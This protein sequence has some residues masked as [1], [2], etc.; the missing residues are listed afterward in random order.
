MDFVFA[1]ERL[2]VKLRHWLNS[3]LASQMLLM[4]WSTKIM[5]EAPIATAT[6]IV[7]KKAHSKRTFCVLNVTDIN[8]V[9]R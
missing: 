1:S 6:K 9:Y 2:V 5:V 8:V 4:W 7:I 3:Q